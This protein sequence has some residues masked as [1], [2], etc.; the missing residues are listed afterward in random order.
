MLGF[1]A[2]TSLTLFSKLFVKF[3]YFTSLL[4]PMS[5]HSYFPGRFSL[6]CVC[7]SWVLHGNHLFALGCCWE[8]LLESMAGS[9][10]LMIKKISV[11]PAYKPEIKLQFVHCEG[12]GDLMLVISQSLPGRSVNLIFFSIAPFKHEGDFLFSPNKQLLLGP[13]QKHG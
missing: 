1:C 5:W 10:G 13:K 6:G 4:R 11:V 8:G 12:Q 3:S 7:V 2:Q 9:C